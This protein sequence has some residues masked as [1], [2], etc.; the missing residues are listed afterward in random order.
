MLTEAQI[1]MLAFVEMVRDLREEEMQSG[2]LPPF[3]RDFEEYL[4]RARENLSRHIQ[5]RR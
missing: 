5:A 4:E 1:R 3:R 2:P